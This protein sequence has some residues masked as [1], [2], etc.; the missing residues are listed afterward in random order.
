[1]KS[2]VSAL[3]S[4]STSPVVLPP[5]DPEVLK[6]SQSPSLPWTKQDPA[7][8]ISGKKPAWMDQQVKVPWEESA[9]EKKQ[10][11]VK[12]EK[13]HFDEDG[14]RITIQH[15]SGSTKIPLLKPCIAIISHIVIF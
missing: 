3:K 4:G 14:D 1:M 6:R 5:V 10:V 7:F 11:E 2:D 13:R 15:A 9:G 12:E 8:R